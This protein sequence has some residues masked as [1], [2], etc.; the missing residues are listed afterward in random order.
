LS[1][2]S[3]VDEAPIAIFLSQ[4]RDAD[5]AERVLVMIAN[6]LAEKG[7]P[8][9]VVLLKGK[10]LEVSKK[11]KLVNLN[12]RRMWSS[13]PKLAGYMRG[14]RPLVFLS[15]IVHANVAALM[16]RR[17]AMVPTKCVITVEN[18]IARASYEAPSRLVRAAYGLSR[19]V[20]PGADGIIT[21]SR[22]LA[23]ELS[24]F[25]KIPRGRITAI[26]NPVLTPEFYEKVQEPVDHPWFQGDCPVILGVGRLTKQ[27]DFAT[28]IRA[29]KKVIEKRPAKLV[30]LGKGRGRSE[31]ERLSEE[32]GIK[33]EVDL[34]GYQANPYAFMARASVFVLSSAWE[35]F[36][37]VVAEAL[38]AGAPVV[39][40]DCPSGPAEILANG[41]YGH[42]V[43]VGD[44][45]KMA[46]A[47]LDV[48]AGNGKKAPPEWL[49]QFDLE[50]VL[51]R[52][53]SVMERAMSR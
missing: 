32:L 36:G 7:H 42:L 10:P 29:F 22:G 23:D 47:I 8:V 4:D 26:Y 25:A 24:Q 40:T 45:D 17:L 43:P 48:L 3:R 16:A 33:S 13:I 21:M 34:P 50:Y 41:K 14:A 38:A 20:Y 37:N 9:E 27:K 49:K 2:K 1:M 52:Y 35:G 19:K 53:L 18:N 12:S 6:A 39:S 51:P 28:L 44:P 15:V 30:I 11:V 46:C 5:G 31:L